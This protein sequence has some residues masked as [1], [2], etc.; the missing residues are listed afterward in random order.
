M[1]FFLWLRAAFVQYAP[2][3]A[4]R[5]PGLGGALLLLAAAFA[6]NSWR[7]ADPQQRAVGTVTENV[8]SFAPG[9]GVLY[10]P[11]LRFRTPDGKLYQPL[12]G[13]ASD[14]PEFAPGTT[15]PVLYAA[16]SPQQA[17]IATIWRSYRTAIVL[18]IIGTALFDI[19]LILRLILRRPPA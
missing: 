7:I 10:T 14:E 6:A 17:R 16:G 13:P 18:G 12:V 2:G 9:G 1:G 5:L 8:A 15:L 11:R 3:A 4:R 19:G